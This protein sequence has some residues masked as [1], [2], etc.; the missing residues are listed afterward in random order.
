MA[1][2]GQTKYT[3]EDMI[4]AIRQASFFAAGRL[5]GA[6]YD[7][8]RAAFGGPCK[9]AIIARFGTWRA[10]CAAAG[11]PANTTRSYTSRWTEADL[12][13]WVAAYLADPDVRGTYDG[14]ADWAKARSGAP[15]GPR[16]RRTFPR[17]RE[18]KAAASR[19][20]AARVARAA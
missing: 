11:V 2:N 19:I 15:S 4:D 17:W 7:E 12:I 13:D 14:Y 5:R 6:A 9:M 1:V 3:D 8:H 10:G 18:V 16:L 20:V